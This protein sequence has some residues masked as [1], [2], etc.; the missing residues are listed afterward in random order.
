MGTEQDPRHAGSFA[1]G[2][3]TLPE[4]EHRGSFAEGE[5]EGPG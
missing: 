3:E 2:E 1:E 4:D 5:E